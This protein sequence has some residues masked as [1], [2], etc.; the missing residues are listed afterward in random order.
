MSTTRQRRCGY[1]DATTRHLPR[2]GGLRP[3]THTYAVT[4]TCGSATY[5]HVASDGYVGYVKRVLCGKGLLEGG[6]AV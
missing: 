5:W 6:E 4:T 2:R 1:Y 3:A